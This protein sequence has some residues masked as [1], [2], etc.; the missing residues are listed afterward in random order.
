MN[1]YYVVDITAHSML[2]ISDSLV[3]GEGERFGPLIILCVQHMGC[4]G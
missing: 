1:P 2:V 3:V 4:G